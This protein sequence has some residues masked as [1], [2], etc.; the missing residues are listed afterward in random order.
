[1]TGVSALFAASRGERSAC[2]VLGTVLATSI[3]YWRKPTRGIR[4]SLDI[5]AVC[6][7]GVYTLSAAVQI[8]A[9]SW[10][11]RRARQSATGEPVPPRTTKPPAAGT[12]GCT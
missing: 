2:A 8:C 10:H 9:P 12:K 6:T 5:A 7:A 4:R 1:L 3:N 11:P